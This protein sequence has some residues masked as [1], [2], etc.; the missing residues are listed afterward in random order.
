MPIKVSLYGEGKAFGYQMA[1]I[2]FGTGELTEWAAKRGAEIAREYFDTNGPNGSW[3]PLHEFTQRRL[4]SKLKITE[5]A[6]VR[7]APAGTGKKQTLIDTEAMK[8]SIQAVQI[9]PRTWAVICTDKKAPIHEY[10]ITIEVSEKQRRWFSAL[11][12]DLRYETSTITIPA[13]RFMTPAAEQLERELSTK[14]LQG[15]MGDWLVPIRGVD[16]L[17]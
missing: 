5:A 9:G 1:G 16:R 10:G 4:G 15:K 13:R 17:V 7:F 11:G 2:R 14:F 6:G 3:A 12:F 8:N